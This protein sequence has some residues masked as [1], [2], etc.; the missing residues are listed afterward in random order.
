MK[1]DCKVHFQL[2][3]Q[4][5]VGLVLLM[6]LTLVGP[7]QAAI[8]SADNDV[9][10]ITVISDA[11]VP[12]KTKERTTNDEK[13][14]AMEAKLKVVDEVNS[15]KDVELVTILGDVVGD[16]GSAEE[17]ALAKTFI[18]RFQ[19]PLVGIAGNHEA[20]YVDYRDE[21]GKLAL[22]N[23]E[24]RLNKMQKGRDLY[25]VKDLYQ[26]RMV[27]NYLLIF[28][29]IDGMGNQITEISKKQ[30]DWFKAQLAA[31]PK[32]PTIVFM[33]APLQGTLMTYDF[34]DINLPK[35]V[36]QPMLEIEEI[37]HQNPQV[38]MWVSGHTH[39]P[40]NNPSYNHPINV[41]QKQVTN[42]H[43]SAW[44]EEPYCSNSLYL[45]PD[46]VV[47]RTYNHTTGKWIENLDRVVRP[48][49]VGRKAS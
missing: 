32:K 49:K 31:N 42:V 36:A 9:H 48:N 4:F 33:H 26:S 7:G 38:F 3:K 24:M 15:W 18:G 22:S 2:G 28:L 10:R 40:F 5:I 37:L 44:E 12:L 11:H 43:N 35:K 13:L 45:Y 19:K 20:M 39:T 47:I 8:A 1:G 17:W 21:K 6:C 27:G 23:P 46:K 41:Y 16:G 29:S 34:E 30:L 25:G 14:R